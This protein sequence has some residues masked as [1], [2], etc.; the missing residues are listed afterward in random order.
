MEYTTLP[1]VLKKLEK[2]FRPFELGYKPKL[3]HELEEL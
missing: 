1:D 3:R 2:R